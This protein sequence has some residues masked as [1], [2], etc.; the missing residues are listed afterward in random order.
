MM[1]A[2]DRS[3]K[4]DATGLG[5]SEGTATGGALRPLRKIV[6]A[7]L[8]LE[9]DQQRLSGRISARISTTVSGSQSRRCSQ[10]GQYL[11]LDD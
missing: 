1:R 7:V 5:S 4:S 6:A 2:R 11:N 10:T 8:V 9:C 3:I